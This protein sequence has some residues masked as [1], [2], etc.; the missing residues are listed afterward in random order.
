MDRA[1][2]AVANK[3]IDKK[4]VK[5]RRDQHQGKLQEIAKKPSTNYRQCNMDVAV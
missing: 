1:L 4:W 2:P 3:L 5:I